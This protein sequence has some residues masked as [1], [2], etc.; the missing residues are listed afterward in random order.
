MTPV[1]LDTGSCDETGARVSELLDGELDG[2]A[3]RRVALHL[4]VC[5]PC[6]Q[7]A[8]QLRAVIRAL[9]RLGRRDG[10]RRCGPRR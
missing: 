2:A 7:G 6:A 5:A 8:E 3:A 9:H 10:T 4:A 1:P